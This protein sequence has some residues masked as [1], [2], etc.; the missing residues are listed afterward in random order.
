MSRADGGLVAADML[1]K[2]VRSRLESSAPRAMCVLRP[3][4]LRITSLPLGHTEEL[5]PL[6]GR[7]L[8]FSREVRFAIAASFGGLFWMLRCS[9]PRRRGP[10][11]HR[12]DRVGMGMGDVRRLMHGWRRF[13]LTVLISGQIRAHGPS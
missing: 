4:R 3:L 9:W 8:S 5:E 10:R 11:L 1:A 2:A 12:V 7:T 6:Q 13:S